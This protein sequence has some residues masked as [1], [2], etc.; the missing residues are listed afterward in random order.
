MSNIKYAD[1]EKYNMLTAIYKEGKALLE[2]YGIDKL[3]VP[4]VCK[5]KE[6]QRKYERQARRKANE[7][8]E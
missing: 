2:A 7:Q 3:N 6:L 5:D 8:S 1:L 4:F